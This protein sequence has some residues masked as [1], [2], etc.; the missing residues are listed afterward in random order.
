M[1]KIIVLFLVLT[2]FLVACTH[3]YI[4]GGL[5]PPEYI[6]TS[7][8]FTF[9]ETKEWKLVDERIFG[10]RIYQ[11]YERKISKS[12]IEVR[13]FYVENLQSHIVKES[14]IDSLPQFN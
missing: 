2:L 12:K 11:R 13:Y 5:K 3:V 10:N 8:W 7:G 1:K 9:E 6:V 14:D 4:G